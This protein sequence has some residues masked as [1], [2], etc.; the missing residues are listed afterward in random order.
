MQW[1]GPCFS[2]PILC[3]D[4]V[5]FLIWVKSWSQGCEIESHIGLCIERG[6]YLRFS[7]SPSLSLSKKGGESVGCLSG[8][9]VK[10]LPSAQVMIPASFQTQRGVCFSLSLCTHLCSLSQ[11]NKIIFLKKNLFS[12]CLFFFVHLFCFLNS[13]YKLNH[14]VFVFLWLAYFTS[15]YIS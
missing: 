7:L 8:Q 1:S 15:H 10:H 14:M 13:T 6:V 5:Q 11:I 4:C 2:L 12:G 3:F 9:W